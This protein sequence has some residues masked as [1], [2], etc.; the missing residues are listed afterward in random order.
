[1]KRDLFIIMF[2]SSILIF[3]MTVEEIFDKVDENM[4][5]KNMKFTARMNILEYNENRELSMD[6]FMR[7]ENNILIE[8]LASSSGH[9][10]RFMK[11][12]DQMWLYIPNAGKAIR[13]K[14]HMLK[15]GFMGSDFSYE[16]M[17]E[18][19][20]TNDL[21][22]MELL[23]EDTLY[24]I[25]L[26]AKSSD[27]P[28]KMKMVYVKKDIFIPI[29][30][31]IY[32]SSERLL[33]E[34]IINEYKKIGEK[35][36]PISMLMYDKLKQNSKTEIVYENIEMNAGIDDKYFQKSYFER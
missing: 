30:E 13:I 5:Y 35:Y 33:K 31:E 19:R 7:D 14:G 12:N 24:I 36:I 10:N 22:N 20:K 17:S 9:T 23:S 6:I 28:Y 8:I 18:N 26:T 25:K 32:S 21:Y 2:I 15:E 34:L 1:M 27:A 29:R 3:P 11:K 16:D 4:V